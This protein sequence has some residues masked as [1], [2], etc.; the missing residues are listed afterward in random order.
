MIDVDSAAVV[1][2]KNM[3]NKQPEIKIR[4]VMTWFGLP[5]TSQAVA[6]LERMEAAGVVKREL[7]ETYHKWYLVK[8]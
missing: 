2:K 4:D 3:G 6:L 1:L 7:V 5:S 8:G